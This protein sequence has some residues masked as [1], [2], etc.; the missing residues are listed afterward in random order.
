MG[1]VFCN[2]PV[3]GSQAMQRHWPWI[4]DLKECSL[5]VKM[6]PNCEAGLPLQYLVLNSK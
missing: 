4:F 6:F 1:F 5:L 2:R 3:R